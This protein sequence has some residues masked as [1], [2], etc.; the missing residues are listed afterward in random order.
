MRNQQSRRGF[1]LVELLV[2][3]AI[4]GILIGLLLP[5]VQSAREAARQAQCS[6]QLKQWGLAMHNYE[7]ANH[8]F[9]FGNKRS[10]DG[11]RISYPP[12]LWPYIEQQALY[13][14]YDFSL[15]FYH[16]S[17]VGDGNEHLVMVQLPLY[18]CPSDRQGMWEGADAYVRSRGN[19]VLNW[20][21]GSFNQS[22]GEDNYE[23]PP[24]FG[25][26][27]QCR[28][29]DIRDGLSNTMLMSEVI[30][31][32][33]DE[34]FDFRGDILNDDNTCA[35]YMT[36]NTPNSGVDYNVCVNL[37][38]PSECITATTRYVSARSNHTGGVYV[39]FGDSSVRFVNDSIDLDTWRAWG[40]MAGGELVR[41]T[42]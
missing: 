6:N 31:A 39:L 16:S 3:I 41:H 21:N 10:T 8:Y 11:K 15:P 5:A 17:S 42:D 27:R 12:A 38:Y 2:V 24:P 14:Q 1:T 33:A 40:S 28:V 19:Y 34:D 23:N 22:A 36:V 13:D 37:H 26:Y 18:F 35:Q 4:I 20:G 32:G 9:P 7:N 29:A 30:Q 25:R